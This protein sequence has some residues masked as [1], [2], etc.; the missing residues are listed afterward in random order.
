[1]VAGCTG[2]RC[3]IVV[4]KKAG[5]FKNPFGAI[6]VRVGVR[7]GLIYLTSSSSSPAGG[8]RAVRE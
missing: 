6:G 8:V 5:V 1:M 2:G 7:V 4:V 3:D